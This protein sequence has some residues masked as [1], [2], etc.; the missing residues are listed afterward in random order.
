MVHYVEQV[1]QMCQVGRQMIKNLVRIKANMR[2]GMGPPKCL[3]SCVDVLEKDGRKC[4]ANFKLMRGSKSIFLA[5][6]RLLPEK[7]LRMPLELIGRRVQKTISYI[8]NSSFFFIFFII[9]Y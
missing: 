8:H 5:G 4:S 6:F 2:R 9:V 3:E 7:K 1:W